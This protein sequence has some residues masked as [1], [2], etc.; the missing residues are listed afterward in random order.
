MERTVGPGESV[1]DVSIRS[2]AVE[3]SA[4]KVAAAWPEGVRGRGLEREKKQPALP[5]V[6]A[7]SPRAL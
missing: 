1:L 2:G 5:A 4:G 3:F 7:L 6:P